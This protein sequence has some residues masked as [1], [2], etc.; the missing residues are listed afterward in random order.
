MPE[1]TYKQNLDTVGFA[2]WLFEGKEITRL[3]LGPSLL[4]VGGDRFPM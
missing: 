4:V 1:L 2:V 3:A